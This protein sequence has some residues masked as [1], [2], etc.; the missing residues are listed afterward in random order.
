LVFCG[1]IP[2]PMSSFCRSP[3][4]KAKLS[5][6]AHSTSTDSTGASAH[7]FTAGRDG[8]AIGRG[9]QGTAHHGD[10]RH[11]FLGEAKRVSREVERTLLMNSFSAAREFVF[12]L[13]ATCSTKSFTPSKAVGPA[14]TL[15]TVTPV[16]AVV[17]P[18]PRTM[19]P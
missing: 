5:L 11:D 7:D 12:R 14:S 19:V 9:R 10:H 6:S 4:R 1:A 18:G 3:S 15:F 13:T 17:S 16:P 2:I 8:G